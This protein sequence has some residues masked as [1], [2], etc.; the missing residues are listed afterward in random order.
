MSYTDNTSSLFVLCAELLTEALNSLRATDVFK[1]KKASGLIFH[2][3]RFGLVGDGDD[4][5]FLQLISNPL[6]KRVY[7]SNTALPFLGQG[8]F[9]RQ[10]CYNLLMYVFFSKYK[11]TFVDKQ[12]MVSLIK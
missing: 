5:V 2:K 7:N 4:Y 6:K 10:S 8:Y 12:Q 1:N 11:N 3:R 9:V